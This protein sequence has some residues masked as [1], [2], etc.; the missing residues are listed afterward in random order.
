M[1]NVIDL[2][3]MSAT[4]ISIFQELD[5]LAIPWFGENTEKSFSKS[6]V[7]METLL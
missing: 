6:V 5:G 1:S 3:S 4:A 7:S 2:S